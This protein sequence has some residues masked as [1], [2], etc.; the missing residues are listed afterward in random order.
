MNSLRSNNL[1]LKYQRF[2]TS[3]CKDIGI[4]QFQFLVKAEFLDREFVRNISRHVETAWVL[5][6]KWNLNSVSVLLIIIISGH[7]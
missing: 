7:K 6:G 3:G 2:T 1:S 4:K 5:N